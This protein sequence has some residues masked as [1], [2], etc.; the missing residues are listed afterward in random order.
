MCRKKIE[1]SRF[2]ATEVKEEI[3]RINNF[4]IQY[5]LKMFF[6]PTILAYF[7]SIDST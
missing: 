5:W 2:L 1:G 4:S 3:V 7:I 6:L